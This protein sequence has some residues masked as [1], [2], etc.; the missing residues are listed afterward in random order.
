MISTLRIARDCARKQA[1]ATFGLWRQL[2][3][4]RFGTFWNENIFFRA[5]RED[6]PS[7]SFV[8]RVCEEYS[9]RSMKS[10]ATKR[11]VGVVLAAVAVRL[12]LVRNYWENLSIDESP[13][14]VAKFKALLSDFMAPGPP[15]L[16]EA[17]IDA[18]LNDG[19]L[20]LNGFA[21]KPLMQVE[22]L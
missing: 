3:Y 21:P 5:D 16:S 22:W 2:L 9:G 17:Q 13:A 8:L 1:R 19:Y 14:D 7:Y 15:Q 6:R 11:V 10:G 18:F 20:V 12:L 4:Q